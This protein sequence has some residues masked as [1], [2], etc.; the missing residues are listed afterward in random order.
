M[1]GIAPIFS[2]GISK[3]TKKKLGVWIIPLTILMQAKHTKLHYLH[4][5]N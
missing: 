2:L 4:N 1:L 5:K 3:D